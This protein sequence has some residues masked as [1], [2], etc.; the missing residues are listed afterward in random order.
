MDANEA[1][2]ERGC[3]AVNAKELLISGCLLIGHAVTQSTAQPSAILFGP[4]FLA[5]VQN[6]TLHYA[7]KRH[8]IQ[9]E[10]VIALCLVKM[11]FDA[12]L[13]YALACSLR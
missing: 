3:A 7:R 4:F 5:A 6:K 11:H 8:V 1:A 9:A 12:V 2:D 13:K 10:F